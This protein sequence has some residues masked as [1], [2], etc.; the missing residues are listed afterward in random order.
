MKVITALAVLLLLGVVNAANFK[1]VRESVSNGH[2]VLDENEVHWDLDGR[3]YRDEDVDTN[4]AGVHQSNRGHDWDSWNN[5]QDDREND[6]N[7]ENCGVN[8]LVPVA[9]DFEL[10]R[11]GSSYGWFNYITARMQMPIVQH[12]KRD[13]GQFAINHTS[14]YHW[15]PG[16][17]I[18][19]VNQS[20]ICLNFNLAGPAFWR[21]FRQNNFGG[22]FEWEAKQKAFLR[23]DNVRHLGDNG[24]SVTSFGKGKD[25]HVADRRT[26]SVSVEQLVLGVNRGFNT[27]HQFALAFPCSE[28]FFDW[29]FCRFK[30][31]TPPQEVFA[32]PP[33]LTVAIT[34]LPAYENFVGNANCQTVIPPPVP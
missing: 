28:Q 5:G 25:H 23:T 22:L 29:N 16:N 15:S 2:R 6:V 18:T 14:T 7:V 10:F 26:A 17:T 33:F 1:K 24:W 11:T 34:A 8:P 19:P 9:P 12:I 30:R 21:C 3:P 4:N 32:A 31:G 20:A 13:T 27:R